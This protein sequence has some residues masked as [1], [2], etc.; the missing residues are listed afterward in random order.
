MK[1][2]IL[3]SSG[4]RMGEYNNWVDACN[5]FSFFVGVYGDTFVFEVNGLR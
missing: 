5:A 4:S 1:I 3:S 2:V